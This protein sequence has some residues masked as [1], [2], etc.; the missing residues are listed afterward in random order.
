MFHGSALAAQGG[1]PTA[2]INQ[3]MVGPVLE[4]RNFRSVVWF[5]ALCTGYAGH[6]KRIFA[7]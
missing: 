3:S 2:V 6:L 1:G 4:T 5:L 7:I